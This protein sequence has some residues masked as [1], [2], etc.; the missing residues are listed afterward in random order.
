MDLVKGPLVTTRVEDRRVVR[1]RDLPALEREHVDLVTSLRALCAVMREPPGDAVLARI[2][3]AELH[4]LD[5][6]G[7]EMLTAARLDSGRAD[8]IEEIDLSKELRRCAKRVARPVTLEV[9]GRVLVEGHMHIVRQSI[10]SALALAF[11][12]ADGPVRAT[13]FAHGRHGVVLVSCESAQPMTSQNARLALLHRIV[14]ADDG[15]LIVNRK[16]GAFELRLTY[17]AQPAAGPA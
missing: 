14:R 8:P 12:I 10:A 16:N 9:R 15:R 2:L 4:Q 17:T 5:V 3:D 6:L 11:R 1:A 7:G 13:A